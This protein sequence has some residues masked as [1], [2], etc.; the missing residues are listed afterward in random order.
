LKF[1]T[2]VPALFREAKHRLRSSHEAGKGIHH[3]GTRQLA[4]GVE[5]IGRDLDMVAVRPATE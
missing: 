4:I 1:H 5:V 2:V 3:P